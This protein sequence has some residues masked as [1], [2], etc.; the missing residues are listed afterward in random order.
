MGPGIRN[1]INL[2]D[3]TKT[4]FLTCITLNSTN[5]NIDEKPSAYLSSY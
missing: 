1:Y 2:K 4:V 5:F 3:E